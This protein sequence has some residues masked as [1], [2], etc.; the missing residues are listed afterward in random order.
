MKK[1]KDLPVA[2]FLLTA[3]V[4]SAAPAVFLFIT[5]SAAEF[6]VPFDRQNAAEAVLMI[7]QRFSA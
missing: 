1:L 5:A 2:Y 7:L 3:A 4:F 6:F